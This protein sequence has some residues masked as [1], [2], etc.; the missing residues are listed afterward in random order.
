MPVSAEER[1]FA[2]RIE[3]YH[4]HDPALSDGKN[5]REKAGFRPTRS[6]RTSLKSSLKAALLVAFLGAM[7]AQAADTPQQIVQRHVDT[8]RKG[9]INAVMADFADDAVLVAEPGIF[10]G[11]RPATE[12]T[13]TTGKNN[14]RKFY[15][16]L[17]DKDH[18]AAVKSMEPRI[19]QLSGEVAILHW[20]QFPG[21]PKQVTGMDIFVVRNGKIVIQSLYVDPPKH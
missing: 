18:F 14:V 7:I 11:S 17:V 1:R 13:A 12:A 15:E 10:S 3:C 20:T 16:M 19:E 6:E 4:D 21:T 8:I 9:D 2:T 5:S